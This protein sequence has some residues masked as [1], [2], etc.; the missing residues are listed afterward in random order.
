MKIMVSPI[1]FCHHNM[2][3]NI[4]S[5]RIYAICCSDKI[6]LLR[7]KF[8]QKFSSTQE[9]HCRHDVLPQ[10]VAATSHLTCIN[11]TQGVICHC[12]ML[13]QLVAWCV[14]TLTVFN[15]QLYN[16]TLEKCLP[17]NP[18]VRAAIFLATVS[19]FRSVFRGF[20]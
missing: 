1:E 3:Q 15:S 2:S 16:L 11:Y 5:G 13:L 19:R 17:V 6:M 14:L 20:R 8:S 10:D 18:G 7:Q 4:K 9:A 12:Y